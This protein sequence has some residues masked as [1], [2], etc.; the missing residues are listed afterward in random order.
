VPAAGGQYKE[1]IDA[2]DQ[3]HSA[4]WLLSGAGDRRHCIPVDPLYLV[5]EDASHAIE[6]RFIA[7]A[8]THRA[9]ARHV[10]PM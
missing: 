6:A 4:S 3:A 8:T 1:F 10:R 2:A 5:L 7:L 9:N